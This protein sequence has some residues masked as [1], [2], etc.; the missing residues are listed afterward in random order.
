MSSPL[1]TAGTIPLPSL[2]VGLARGRPVDHPPARIGLRAH[3]QIAYVEALLLAVPLHVHLRPSA[4]TPTVA[5][6][7]RV[8]PTV[9]GVEDLGLGAARPARGHRPLTRGRIDGTLPDLGHVSLPERSIDD[10]LEHN[11][12]ARA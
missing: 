3:R 4:T 10:S 5:A 6:H 7:R 12:R 9:V 11:R 8:E 2:L 1:V